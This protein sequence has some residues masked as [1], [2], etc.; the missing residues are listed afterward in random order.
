MAAVYLIRHGQ[1]SFG[2]HH[3]DALSP[4]G[5]QQAEQLGAWLRTCAIEPAR[6]YSGSMQRQQQT[7]QHTCAALEL[8]DASLHTDARLNE[9]DYLDVLSAHIPNCTSD[10]A[11]L[12]F[13]RQQMGDPRRVF[14]RI[15]SEAVVHWVAH[16]HKID[17]TAY[18]ETWREFQQRAQAA[19][20]DAVEF[21][22]NDNA[23]VMLFTSGGVISAMVQAFEHTGGALADRLLAAMQ[24]AMDAGGE[25]GPVHSAA[26]KV[27]GE[28]VWP[29]I[30]LRVDWA[31]TDPIA[32][33][34]GLWRAYQPQMQDYLTR[35]LN[36][37]TAPS[38]GVPGDE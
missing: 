38:Y 3:Y 27:V 23:S 32:Q 4:L 35:A 10:A 8:A 26:L 14:Q 37:T 6:W 34:A 2:T 33:L 13:L 1:A 28:V 31:D 7:A 16:T 12:D 36:P 9:F 30:D 24:A 19:L 21:A 18:R 20:A 22:C 11:L 15:F 25:A 17:G 29:I 5:Q